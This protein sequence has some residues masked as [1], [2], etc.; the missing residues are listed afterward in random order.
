[1]TNTRTHKSKALSLASLL[2]ASFLINL[3]VTAVNNALPALVRELGSTTTQLQWI[4]DA[5]SLAFA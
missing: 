1:M 4:V 2:V 5:Y 3:E